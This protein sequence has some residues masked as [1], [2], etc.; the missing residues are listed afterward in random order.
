[1]A[2]EKSSTTK[3]DE[4]LLL[5]HLTKLGTEYEDLSKKEKDL[6]TLLERLKHEERHLKASLAIV[7]QSST[8]RKP[9]NIQEQQALKRLED[10]LMEDSSS[11]SDEEISG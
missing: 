2:T 7:D 1:M 9:S 5:N 3:D 6:E 4:Q 8:N 10:A 11:S